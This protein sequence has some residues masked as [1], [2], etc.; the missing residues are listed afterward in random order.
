MTLTQDTIGWIVL[1]AVFLVVTIGMVRDEL[2][3]IK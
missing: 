3:G 1:A 2:R